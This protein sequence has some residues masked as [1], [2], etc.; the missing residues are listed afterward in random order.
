MK[1][2]I[3]VRNL[4]KTFADSDF[5]LDL[6]EFD[7]P[8][9]YVTGLV[10]ENG[11]GKTTLLK[12]LTGML[13]PDSGSLHILGMDLQ[14]EGVKIRERIAL[15]GEQTGLLYPFELKVIKKM[16]SPFYGQWDETL[17]QNLI[18]RFSL[19]LNAHG[20]ALSR[21]Q[22]KLFALAM[23]VSHHPDLLLLDEPTANLD[24]AMREEI[25]T[26]MREIMLQEDITILF[27]THITTD[28]DKLADQLRMFHKGRMLL[29][30]DKDLLL[31]KHRVVKGGL[32]LLQADTGNL[33]W[34]IER[35]AFGFTA[36]TDN[37]EAVYELFGD[38]AYYEA[39]DVERLFLAYLKTE[40]GTTK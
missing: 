2:A 35:S 25:L 21:G 32:E 28:L 5:F 37:F 23:A 38:E 12:L 15:I 13:F 39:P 19:D 6:A 33:L 11:A 14:K 7:V 3:E 10:G 40:R 4:K 17:F 16:I 9:G 30:G 36:M 27:S 34:N 31:E 1:N 8:R 24:P 20:D 29:Q 18:E 22:Q 26:L